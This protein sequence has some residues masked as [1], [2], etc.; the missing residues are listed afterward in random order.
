MGSSPISRPGIIF[1]A[2][3]QLV[4][5]GKINYLI[6]GLSGTGKSTIFEELIRRGYHAISSDRAWAYSADPETGLPG[7]PR[8]HDNFMWTR[9]KPSQH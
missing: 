7:G 8:H 3:F 2:N 5:Y 6:D 4:D 9:P 1:S